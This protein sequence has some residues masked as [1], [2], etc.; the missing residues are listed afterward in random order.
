MKLV[1]VQNYFET[2]FGT[3]YIS[4]AAKAKGHDCEVFV[5]THKDNFIDEVCNSNPDIV[6]FHCITGTHPWVINTANKIKEKINVPIIVG[7]PHPTFFPEVIHSE[8]IDIICMGEGEDAVAE[9]VDRIDNK[10]DISNIRNLWVKKNGEISKNSMRPFVSDLDMLYPPDFAIYDKYAILK[11]AK[12]RFYVGSRGCAFSCSY[13]FNKTLRDMYEKGGKYFRSLSVERYIKDTA[14]LKTN[15]NLEY[16][17]F[18]DSLFGINRRWLEEFT[19]EFKKKVNIPFIASMEA[20]TIDENIV[21]KLKDCGCYCISFGLE[22]GNEQ[23]RKNVLNKNVGNKEI[24]RSAKIIKNAGIKLRTS[25]MLCL[26]SETIEN[27][28]ETIK[29]NSEIG[30]DFPWSYLVQPYPRTR[31]YDFA[32]KNGF[33]EKSF[34]F[35]DID[36]L[37]MF[38]SPIKLKEAKV[39]KNLHRFFYLGVK[40]PRLLWLLTYVSYI[41]SNILFDFIHKITMTYNYNKY[42]KM[43]IF[44]AIVVGLQAIKQKR[45]RS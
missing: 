31:I 8:G 25:N 35:D 4:S 42:H 15:K 14:Y 28:L 1:F 17:F 26:P 5:D 11:N 40:F 19:V 36:P 34:S 30:T 21:K 13:C 27:A 16:I 18:C 9:L 38:D 43:G 6:G 29:L 32:V 24:I 39:I 7:G 41:K 45:L 23:L 3:M 33:L 12:E 2:Y 37:A 20:S 22:T 10:E 44:K